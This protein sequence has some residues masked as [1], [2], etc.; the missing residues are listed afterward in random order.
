MKKKMI[1][2]S[3]N[4]NILHPGHLRLFKFAKKLGNQLYVGIFSDKIAGDEAYIKENLRYEALSA[5][6]MIDKVFLIKKDISYYIKKIK[7]DFVV[8]GKEHEN[9]FNIEKKYLEKFGGKLIFSS[10]EIVFSSKNLFHKEAYDLKKNG[11]LNT[12]FNKRHKIT[13]KKIYSIINDFK[14]IKSIVIGDTIIDEY[15]FCESLG[16]SQEDNSIIYKSDQNQK[17]IGGA[18]IVASH[19]SSLGANVE[20]LTILGNDHNKNFVIEKLKEYK[21]NNSV[22]TDN[23][24][25]TNL[26]VRYKF[27]NNTV[28]RLSELSNFEVDKKIQNKIFHRVKKLV[29]DKKINLIIFSDF[30]YG[31]LTPDLINRI[32]EYAK[33]RNICLT[34]DSQISSQIGDITKYKDINLLSSTEFEARTSLKNTN[35]GLV[36]LSEKLRK[37]TNNLNII[38]KLQEDGVFIHAANKDKNIKSEYENDEIYAINKSPVDTAGAGDSMLVATSLSLALGKDIWTSTL[39]GNFAAAIQISRYG[40]QP[41]KLTELKKIIKNSL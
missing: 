35:D 24:R 9:E 2:I 15:I 40:N 31:L 39:L 37:I 12:N 19:L 41:I 5:N 23:S 17:F 32:I 6:K 16:L 30:N 10:G 36:I 13:K 7:P 26:K 28:F 29:D 25:S 8:K 38:L 22:I 14:K 27:K 18:G 11:N 21:I 20:L 4:F 33:K 3:G 1:L 34:A